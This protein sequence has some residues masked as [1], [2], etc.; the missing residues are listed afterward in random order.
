MTPIERYLE[1]LDNI[2]QQE[3]LF[4]KEEALINGLPGVTAIVYTDIPEK[5]LITALTYGL[6]HVEHPA[7]KLGRPELCISVKSSDMAWGRA[8]GFLANQLRGDCPFS[9]GQIINLHEQISVDSEMDAFFVFAPSTLDKEDYSNIDIGTDYK[10]NIAGLYPMYSDE[11][12]I[13]EQI[14]LEKFWQ[15]PDFDNYSVNRKRITGSF[16]KI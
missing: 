11:I 7:W 16:K 10:I 9:Y 12:E 14:G 15:H 2:F 6:S 1:H 4:Y 8:A 13:Y 3:P 5:G